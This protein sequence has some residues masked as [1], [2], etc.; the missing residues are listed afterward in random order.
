MKMVSTR[1]WQANASAGHHLPLKVCG[2]QVAPMSSSS[3][4]STPAKSGPTGM[5]SEVPYKPKRESLRSMLASIFGGYVE[6]A[7][8]NDPPIP[9]EKVNF[10]DVTDHATGEEKLFLLAFENGILDPY[11]N[12]PTERNGRG[13]KDNPV[14]VESFAPWRTV[15]CICENTQTYLK[16]TRLYMGEPKR[17]QCG[18]WMK[19]VE[20]P[21]FWEKIPKEDLVEIAFFR[22]LEE[23]G[24]L[25]K[26]LET[27]KLE[28]GD[29][30]TLH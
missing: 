2:S 20:A 8:P 18:H 19:L 27:G 12:L 4:S 17:C 1:L 16:Y 22:E 29:H 10:P 11:C 7:N 26:F 15:A 21:R 25:D 3:S 9:A 28:E 24:K 14:P 5:S 13:T 30:R 6:P 23:E